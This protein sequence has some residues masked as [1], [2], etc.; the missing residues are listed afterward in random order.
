MPRKKPSK[1]REKTVITCA[2]KN[3]ES[4]DQAASLEPAVAAGS[5]G[6]L[7]SGTRP[8]GLMVWGGTAEI[9]FLHTVGSI[10]SG[11]DLPPRAGTVISVE[12]VVTLGGT[13]VGSLLAKVSSAAREQFP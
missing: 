9:V 2:S 5:R 10:R 6:R 1:V 7:R 4:K 8:Y 12:P 11:P 13:C 3:L